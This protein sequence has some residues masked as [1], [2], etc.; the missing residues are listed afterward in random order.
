[1]TVFSVKRSSPLLHASI[2]L[3]DNHLSGRTGLSSRRPALVKERA[4][5][6]ILSSD[7]SLNFPVRSKAR[8]SFSLCEPIGRITSHPVG[9]EHPNHNSSCTRTKGSEGRDP[10]CTAASCS[11]GYERSSPA[12][13]AEPIGLGP[14]MSS[15]LRIRPSGWP[16]WN[17]A[18]GHESP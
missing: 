7:R 13:P 5:E 9:V 4:D 12:G 3:L 17:D 10:S 14:R 16:R 15:R 2:S 8:A 18:L 6:A 1:M 11:P